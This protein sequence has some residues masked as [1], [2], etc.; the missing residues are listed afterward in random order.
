MVPQGFLPRAGALP[1]HQ[2]AKLTDFKLAGALGSGAMAKVYEAVHITTGRGVAIKILEPS[3]SEQSAPAV[4][5]MPDMP[6]NVLL[7]GF[8]KKTMARDPG[9]RFQ[10]AREMLEHWWN[11]MVS[12]DKQGSIDVMRGIGRVDDSYARP[13]LRGAG[14]PAVIDAEP[15]HNDD[16]DRT[17]RWRAPHQMTGTSGPPSLEAPV[18]SG[19]V[20]MPDAA[21]KTL[22]S[23]S[24]SEDANPFDVPTRSDPNLKHLVEQELELHRKRKPPTK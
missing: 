1:P 16:E 8:V 12:L 15:E 22:L 7:D 4:S 17:E 23:T 6:K 9:D 13:F 5:R 24:A 10:N 21:P 20:T 18:S 3:Q 2:P 11:V 19:D 14:L